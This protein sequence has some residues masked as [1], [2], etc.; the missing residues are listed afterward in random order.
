MRILIGILIVAAVV[1]GVLKHNR[2]EQPAPITSAPASVATKAQP[3]APQEPSKHNW[4]KRT[5]DRVAEVKQQV[6]QQKKENEP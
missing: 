3:P 6:A 5:L 1:G 4:P 2:R